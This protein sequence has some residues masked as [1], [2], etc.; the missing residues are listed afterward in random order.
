MISQEELNFMTMVLI[1]PRSENPFVAAATQLK[2]LCKDVSTVSASA[3]HESEV[4]SLQAV[5]TNTAGAYSHRHAVYDRGCILPLLPP[6]S[7]G[8]EYFISGG[9]I[10]TNTSLSRSLKAI[11][12][13]GMDKVNRDFKEI[14]R[15]CEA[16]AD[17]L[18]S[19]APNYNSTSYSPVQLLN[20]LNPAKALAPLRNDIGVHSRIVL[21]TGLIDLCLLASL[22]L[23]LLLVTLRDIRRRTED[24][25]HSFPNTDDPEAAEL[26]KIHKRLKQEHVSLVAY[27][28]AAY[29]STMMFIP[30]L[31]WA[32]SYP[33][34]NFVQDKNW[35]LGLQ[36]GMHGPFAISGNV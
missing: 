20:I 32:L 23:P 19:T 27:A 33:G 30:T 29:F 31:A 8:L 9:I 6:C 16:V 2:K 24:L 11:F 26:V 12:V 10:G 34:L 14:K 25:F 18:E 21:T 1:L 17:T 15:I 36:I 35:L 22:Y 13:W 28:F 5:P 7:M 4:K 3:L